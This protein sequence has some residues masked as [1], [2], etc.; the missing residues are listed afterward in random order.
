VR[1]GEAAGAC[2]T[3]I[4]VRMYVCMYVYMNVSSVY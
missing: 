1:P 4:R 2:Y 3:S